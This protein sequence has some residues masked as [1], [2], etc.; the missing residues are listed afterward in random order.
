MLD[1]DIGE[2]QVAIGGPFM[3]IEVIRHLVSS[4][5]PDLSKGNEAVILAYEPPMQRVYWVSHMCSCIYY[6]TRHN[7]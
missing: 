1:I 6:M 7:S 2:T 3:Y 4:T 5:S